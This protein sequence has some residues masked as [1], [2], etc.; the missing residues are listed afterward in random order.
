MSHKYA[1]WAFMIGCLIFLLTACATGPSAVQAPGASTTPD[2]PK[3][4]PLP[5]GTVLYKANWSHG[6]S[7][8]QGTRGW[9]VVNGQLEADSNGPNILTIPYRPTVSDY[10][11]EVRLR[12]MRLL[13]P[14]GGYFTIA[15]PKKMGKDGYQAGVNNLL[16][17]EPRPNGSHPQAQVFIDP[18]S[19]TAPGSALPID[20]EPGFGWHIYRVE[21]QGNE[22]RLLADGVQIGRA[23]SEQTNVLSNGPINLST[24]STVLRV[25]SLRVVAM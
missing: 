15:A 20:Y 24:A 25:S 13:K 6:L 18:S 8:W 5:A 17:I 23:S 7:S 9:K 4:T 10:A 12:V 2:A 22:A 16:G 1:L 3:A 21:V 14:N 11:I 19:S